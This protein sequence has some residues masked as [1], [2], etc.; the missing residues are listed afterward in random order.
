[1]TT[2]QKLAV[3]RRDWALSNERI[4]NLSHLGG[5]DHTQLAA[6][7][8]REFNHRRHLKEQILRLQKDGNP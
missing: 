3:L 1:M 6:M 8:A 4:H 2:L 7:L 5:R